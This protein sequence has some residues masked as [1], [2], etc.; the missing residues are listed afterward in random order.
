MDR[1]HSARPFHQHWPLL[2]HA[3]YKPAFHLVGAKPKWTAS[4]S[5]ALWHQR[6]PML[7]L[8]RCKRAVQVVGY[9]E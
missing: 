5:L 3:G 9:A 4:V 6:L 8:A 2:Q 7:Q 1:E